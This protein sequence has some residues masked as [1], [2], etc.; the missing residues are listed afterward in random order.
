MSVT[1]TNNAK[2][3]ENIL[4]ASMPVGI[5]CRG[6]APCL[7]NMECYGLR[8]NL[9]FKNYKQSMLNNLRLYKE[10]PEGY[11][12]TIDTQLTLVPYRY[13]RWFVTGDIPDEKF[14]N[15]IM[16][17]LAIEHPGTKFLAFTKKYEIVNEW[18]TE[19]G[20]LPENLVIILSSWDFFIPENPY[21][22][23]MSFVRFKEKG[24]NSK[25][26]ADA[27][28]C[29]GRCESCVQAGSGCWNLKEGGI[30]CI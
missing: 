13:F 25:I 3:G 24:R 18:I 12:K 14:F 23:P 4:T 1:S 11:F 8:G 16:V 29:P 15:E 20:K 5:T 7:L 10:N 27:I 26:P 30:R 22:L 6:N 2:V 19:N 21:D 17:G 28:K 9:A